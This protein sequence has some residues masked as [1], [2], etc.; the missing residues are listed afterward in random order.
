MYLFVLNNKH[1]F[2]FTY[3]LIVNLILLLIY[4]FYDGNV[5]GITKLN[6]L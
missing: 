1:I 6:K 2:I 5:F 4:T 3:L